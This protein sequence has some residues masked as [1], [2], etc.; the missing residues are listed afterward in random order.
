MEIDEDD[1]D[2]DTIVDPTFVAVM[3]PDS[4]S[5]NIDVNPHANSNT[6]M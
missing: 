4:G 1:D 2:D 5:T 6:T 3:D